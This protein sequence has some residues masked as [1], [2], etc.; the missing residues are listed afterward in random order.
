M[1]VQAGLC[2]TCS[3]TT[4]LVFPRDGSFVNIIG[5]RNH[6]KCLLIFKIHV[7]GPHFDKASNVFSILFSFNRL[8]STA[9]LNTD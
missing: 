1:L 5:V 2:G 4:L 8:I 6:V 7:V 9:V 3:E